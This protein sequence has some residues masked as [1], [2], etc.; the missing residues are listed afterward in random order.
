MSNEGELH[1]LV[2]VVTGASEN[3]GKAIARGFADAGADLFLVARRAGPLDAV[4]ADIHRR[5]GRRCETLATDVAAPGATSA[6]AAESVERFGRVHVL[7][8]NA[9]AAGPRDR[10]LFATRDDDWAEVLDVNVLAPFRL[11]RDLGSHMR[12]HGGGSIVNVISGSGL[13]PSPTMAPYGV[14]KAALWMLTRY[15]AVQAAPEVRVNA[16]CPGLVTED[17]EPRSHAQAALLDRVPMGRL[18][19]PEEI[20]GAAVYLAS[21]RNSYTTGSLI[22]ANGGRPW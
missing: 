6:I 17:G 9:F 1:G 18:G 22:V 5:T 3:I 11:C 21:P 7:V 20:V 16:L 8:N 19:R 14:S 12:D 4:A 10:D 15:L 2:A 13:T